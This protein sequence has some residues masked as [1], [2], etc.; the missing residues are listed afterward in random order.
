VIGLH[1]GSVDP[2]Q[3]D[4]PS[5]EAKKAKSLNVVL[6]GSNYVSE[7]TR[8]AYQNA[9]AAA[10]GQTNGNQLHRNNQEMPMAQETGM[11]KATIQDNLAR[12]LETFGAH[13]GEL[14][15]VYQQ[16]LTYQAE[17]MNVFV[18]LMQQQHS[19]IANTPQIPLEI[20]ESMQR[21]MNVFH[22]HQAHTLRVHE[23]YLQ[24]QLQIT[25]SFLE[26]LRQQFTAP[27]QNAPHQNGTHKAETATSN[28]SRCPSPQWQ[29]G[30]S[31]RLQPSILHPHRLLPIPYCLSS[32][33]KLDIQ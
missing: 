33:I 14:V 22:E 29:T 21:S 8:L 6:N 26:L 25:Q 16:Y 1:L 32:A 7:K 20:L 2:Y 19:L 17:Y 13:Q 11:D 31:Q 15:R 24:Q 18:Q 4:F 3:R 28:R 27:S 5:P 9:L 30:R 23:E 12:S 10:S